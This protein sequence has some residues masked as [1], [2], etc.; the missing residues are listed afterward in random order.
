MLFTQESTGEV[1][2]QDFG[3]EITRSSGDL[4]IQI[5]NLAVPE[6][7]T[8]TSVVYALNERHLEKALNSPASLV[9][10]SLKLEAKIPVEFVEKKLFFF[11]ETPELLARNIKQKYCPTPTPYREPLYGVHPSAVIDPSSE[12]GPHVTV[13]PNV[14][15]GANCSIGE[16]TQIGANAIIQ[17]NVKIG[18]RCSIHSLAFIGHSTEMGECCEIMPHATVGS[19]GF[20]YSQDKVFNHYRIPHTGKVVLG[21]NVHI[22]ANTTIDRGTVQNTSIGDGTKIDNLV[23]VAHNLTIGKNCLI[24]A[25]VVF[26]GSTKVGNNFVVGGNASINGHIDICDNVQVA[27]MSGVNHDITQPG[28]YGGFPIQPMRKFLRNQASFAKLGEIR[29]TVS[30]LSRI[31]KSSHKK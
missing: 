16:G 14:V 8:P 3:S 5:D 20:G 7:A 23:H 1:L 17:S 11:C 26:A 19:E 29:K 10:T 30:E 2:K 31:L 12:L 22:G 27:G 25:C 6:I 28:T 18:K 24:T 4:K 13:G 21:S 15:I 9:L